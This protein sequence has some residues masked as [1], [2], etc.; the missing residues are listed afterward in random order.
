MP[1]DHRHQIDQRAIDVVL[2][3][4]DG[5]IWLAHEPIPGSVAA[6]ER[7][8]ASGR[9]VVFVTNNSAATR[10]QHEAALRRVGIEASGD[11]VSSAMA[12]A[13]LVQPGE[14]VLVAGGEGIVEALREAGADPSVNTGRPLD[15]PVDAVVVGLHRD[16]DYPRLS[17]AGRAV[18]DG[19]RLI[20]TNSD[21]TYP[22]PR[23]LEPGG[24]SLAAAVAAVGG[25][26]PTFA[27][28]PEQPMAKYL[29]RLVDV[30]PE[31]CLMVGDRED[32]DGLFAT[33]IGCAFALVESGVTSAGQGTHRDLDAVVSA[34]D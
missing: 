20:A 24:G 6:V 15:Q 11:V 18:L 5:V 31:R 16:F 34:L 9:R 28:K 10:Q 32:T 27:G 13:T 29:Q 33:R 21:T 7:L 1:R 14:R 22:T 17:V 19:A 25:V 30:G 8:R 3:D 23:G 2:C 12:A 4:L 26:T